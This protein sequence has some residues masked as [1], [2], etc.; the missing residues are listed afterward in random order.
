ML[1][2]NGSLPFVLRKQAET[3]ATN[4]VQPHSPYLKSF[5]NFFVSTIMSSSTVEVKDLPKYLQGKICPQLACDLMLLLST[6]IGAR[7][8]VANH[9]STYMPT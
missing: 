3:S 5:V 6:Y 2:R 9:P 7:N 8:A 4:T 1:R